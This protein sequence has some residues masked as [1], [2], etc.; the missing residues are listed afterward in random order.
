MKSEGPGELEV[1]ATASIGSQ[2][3]EEKKENVSLHGFC[4]AANLLIRLRIQMV[5]WYTDTSIRIQEGTRGEENVEDVGKCQ[6]DVR[7]FD[8]FVTSARFSHR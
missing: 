7:P 2:E 1:R 5:E 8:P 6:F 3:E 4:Y